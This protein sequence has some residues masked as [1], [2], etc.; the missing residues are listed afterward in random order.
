[1]RQ[2]PSRGALCI[3]IT[4]VGATIGRP[5]GIS[6]R[7]AT[8]Q[9]QCD[10]SLVYWGNV[11][12]GDHWSPALYIYI[13]PH[14]SSLVYWGDVCVWAIIGRPIGIS[15]YKAPSRGALYVWYG[16]LYFNVLSTLNR[17][18]KYFIHNLKLL[19]TQKKNRIR[20][21]WTPKFRQ[22]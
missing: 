3:E 4:F 13:K 11:C 2:F 14:D 16:M 5:I 7:Y 9:S 8:P 12:R 21:K 6:F 20:L 18:K 10:S 15:Q 19:S 17:T 22:N 1:M